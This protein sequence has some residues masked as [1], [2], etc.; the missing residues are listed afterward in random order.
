M[1]KKWR[2][3]FFILSV[4]LLIACNTNL[5]NAQLPS[6][7]FITYNISL[8]DS[9]GKL[10]ISLPNLYDTSFSWTHYSDCGKPC[11]RIKYRFQPKTR[12][13]EKES[14]WLWDNEPKDSTERVTISYAASFPLHSIN[15]NDSLFI[16][17]FHENRKDNLLKEP[18]S[19]P[20]KSDTIE[21]IG[22]RFLSIIIIDAYDTTSL[23]Y[24]KKLLAATIINKNP[25]YFDFELLTKQAGLATDSFINNAYTS[26]RSIRLSENK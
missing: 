6:E 13:V 14:G 20:L 10:S 12:K 15:N 17:Q 23:F 24:V 5:K 9:L 26:L 2:P 4:F 25:V 21:R 11:D 8:V 3:L 1:I 7:H 16:M 18:Y 19:Y 22:D